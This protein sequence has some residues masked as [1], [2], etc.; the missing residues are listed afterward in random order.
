[1]YNF[2]ALLIEN[3]SEL[4]EFRDDYTTRAFLEHFGIMKHFPANPIPNNRHFLGIVGY[5]EQVTHYIVGVMFGGFS[6]PED[7]GFVV[8]C[9]PKAG[10]S[11]NDVQHAIQKSYLRF[12]AS[13]TVSINWIPANGIYH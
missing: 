7:N 13:E 8:H 9:I 11:T 1:M 4:V 6:N 10:Y 12:C 2:N 5:A 3:K